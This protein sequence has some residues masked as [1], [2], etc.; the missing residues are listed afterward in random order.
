MVNREQLLAQVIDRTLLGGVGAAPDE[1]PGLN[2]GYG[3]AEQLGMMNNSTDL[4]RRLQPL[5]GFGA[6]AGGFLLTFGAV[7]ALRK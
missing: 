2:P 7:A 3:E 4:W 1:I 5:V 6:F